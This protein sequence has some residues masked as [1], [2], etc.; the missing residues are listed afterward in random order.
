M[1]FL[2][3]LNNIDKHGLKKYEEGKVKTRSR[4]IPYLSDYLIAAVVGNDPIA[5]GVLGL[6]GEILEMG[7]WVK[8]LKGSHKIYFHKIVQGCWTFYNEIFKEIESNEN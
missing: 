3:D 7:C 5:R 6:D 2:V 4:F 8:E 1:C